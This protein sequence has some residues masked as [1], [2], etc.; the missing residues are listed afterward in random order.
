MMSDALKQQI[1]SYYWWHSIDLGNG[2]VTPGIKEFP[3]MRAEADAIFS[4]LDVTGKSVLDVGAWNGGFSLEAH[5]RGAASVT[6]MDH[7]TWTHPDYKGRETFELV[8]R[9]TGANF[10]AIDADL[11]VEALD[12]TGIGDFDVVLF[13]GVFY[14]LKDPI[15]ALRQLVSHT[16][17]VLVVESHVESSQEGDRPSMV[18][19]PGREAN[20]DPTNWWGP[21]KECLIALLKAAGMRTVQDIPLPYGNRALLRASK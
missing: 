19:W 12:L 3:R 4:G 8:S 20:N 15:A 14:H 17:D 5:R 1:A 10:G 11:D 21:N 2:I 18:F 6:G 9:V 13:L 7:F 16:K